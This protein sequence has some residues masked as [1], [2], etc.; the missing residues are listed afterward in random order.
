MLIQPNVKAEVGEWLELVH[1][2]DI[3]IAHLPNAQQ[4]LHLEIRY[5]DQDGGYHWLS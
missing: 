3:A 4:N 1:P 5:L 2:D